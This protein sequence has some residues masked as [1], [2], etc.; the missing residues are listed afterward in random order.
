MHVLSVVI[1][2]FS[3][4]LFS[5]TA[6]ANHSTPSVLILGDSLSA[7]HNISVEKSWPRLFE[8]WLSQYSP[9][10]KVINASISGETTFG[11]RQRLPDLLDKY[12]PD[13]LVIEL[14][15]NDGLRG[16]NFSQ[17]TENL[18]QMVEMA[19]ARDMEVLL[20]GV[21]M[22]P[23]LGPA[24]NARSQ[25]IFN[26]VA[27]SYQISFLPKFLEGVA[28]SDPDLMQSDGI[29]PTEKAQ[30]ILADKV[31]IKIRDMLEHS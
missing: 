3:C 1:V 11:G 10:S 13:T 30:P 6:S 20:V 5:T 28:A 25:E 18:N 4:S 16:F 29:H 21:R 22:P 7:A 31:I 19:L 14:G 27:S 2:L 24:Y 26:T 15:G 17:T 8:T 23:N 9:G 12:Q